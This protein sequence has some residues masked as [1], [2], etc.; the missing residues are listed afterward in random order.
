MKPFESRYPPPLRSVAA[1]ISPAVVEKLWMSMWKGPG[2]R[3]PGALPIGL[4][5]FYAGDRRRGL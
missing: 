1:L 5:D 4:P 2:M 3:R